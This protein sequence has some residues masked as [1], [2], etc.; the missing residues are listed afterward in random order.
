VSNALDREDS[1]RQRCDQC[2][3]WHDAE[4]RLVCETCNDVFC[5]DRC[6]ANHNAVW[7]AEPPKD[8]GGEVGR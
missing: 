7:H 4:D 6:L 1:E 5:S 2:A 3:V 8:P